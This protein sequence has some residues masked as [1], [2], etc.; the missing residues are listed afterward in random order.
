MFLAT[1]VLL[2]SGT[3]FAQPGFEHLRF[4]Q[5]DVIPGEG[6]G[7]SAGQVAHEYRLGIN[8]FTPE[9][10]GF[11]LASIERFMRIAEGLPEGDH[12]TLK[13]VGRQGYI[14]LTAYDT[15]DAPFYV[16]TF[17][18]REPTGIAT[19]TGLEALWVLLA[20]QLPPSV[21]NGSTAVAAP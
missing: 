20:E 17:A 2:L 15:N 14:A 16:L 11:F 19:R 6:A 18:A 5:V 8:A 13:Q 9:Q 1:C 12:V 21:R 3:S 10:L 4:E 7:E